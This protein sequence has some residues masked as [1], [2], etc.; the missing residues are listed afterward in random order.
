MVGRPGE[1]V[2]THD[3]IAYDLAFLGAT[4][5]HVA[6]VFKTT[7]QT[8]NAWKKKHPS[9]LESLKAG[10]QEADTQV[11]RALFQRATGYQHPDCHISNYMGDVTVTPTVKH[12]PPDSTAIIYW[13]SNRDPENWRRNPDPYSDDTAP[14]LQ[15]T[16]SSKPAKGN[17]KVTNAKRNTK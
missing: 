1:Y 8:I 5:A 4:D 7:E 16:F 2:A 15:I 17:V 6:R 13:L 12:Y 11:K 9:F 3:E 10:K 14:A